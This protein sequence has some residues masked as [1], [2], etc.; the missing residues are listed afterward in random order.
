MKL[1]RSLWNL[2]MSSNLLFVEI[3]LRPNPLPEE[4]TIK[5][6]TMFI[7]PYHEDHDEALLPD[8][9]ILLCGQQLM[10]DQYPQ[11]SPLFN[12]TGGFYEFA[13]PDLEGKF[14]LGFDDEGNPK[15]GSGAIFY[16]DVP[17]KI[18]PVR[19]IR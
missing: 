5:A 2:R 14:L 3:D 9:T 10:R 7:V 15:M 12:S 16:Q 8:F 4:A 1:Q 6:G 19:D 11:I 17:P 18:S 13:L